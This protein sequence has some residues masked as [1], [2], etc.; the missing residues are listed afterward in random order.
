MPRVQGLRGARD[1]DGIVPARRNTAAR[2]SEV[3]SDPPPCRAKRGEGSTPDGAARRGGYVPVPALGGQSMGVSLV[4]GSVGAWARVPIAVTQTPPSTQ[5]KRGL[6]VKRDPTPQ[7]RCVG[8]A[9]I[10]SACGPCTCTC[11]TSAG[12]D[13]VR[14]TGQRGFQDWGSRAAAARKVHLHSSSFLLFVSQMQLSGGAAGSPSA[15]ATR[16]RK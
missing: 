9:K 7:G 12:L 14:I 2:A 16:P 5:G 1:R 15:L 10:G 6:R 8:D 11:L 4:V 3:E 13:T